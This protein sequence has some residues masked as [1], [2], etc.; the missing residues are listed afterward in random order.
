MRKTFWPAARS[1]TS[2]SSSMMRSANAAT[3]TTSPNTNGFCV[4]SSNVMVTDYNVTGIGSVI[5][6]RQ[7][8]DDAAAHQVGERRRH[9]RARLAERRQR[10]PIERDLVGQVAAAG[11]IFL[12]VIVG[13]EAEAQA[14]RRAVGVGGVERVQTQLAGRALGRGDRMA[15][16]DAGV[17]RG[18]DGERRIGVERLA[19]IAARQ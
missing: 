3:G 13:G 1:R 10:V 9:R 4:T 2:R 18:D 17:A 5:A 19:R 11:A 7:I 8:E 6:R 15:R 16:E 12:L 14:E